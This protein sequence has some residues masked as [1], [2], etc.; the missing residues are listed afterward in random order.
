MAGDLYA[1]SRT[2]SP[3]YSKLAMPQMD[4]K[5]IVTLSLLVDSR[6]RDYAKYPSPGSYAVRLPQKFLNVR[7][8]MLVSIEMPATF[9]VFTAARGNSTL[10]VGVDG[11]YVNVTIPDGN[12]TQTSMA[13]AL[14]TALETAFMGPTFTITF[15][16][17]TL[18]CTLL[19][20]SGVAIAV[21]TTTTNT[22]QTGW[23]L[24]YYLGFVKNTVASGTGSVTG[25]RIANMNP[26]QYVVLDIEELNDVREMGLYGSG[27]SRKAFAKI[28]IP[29]NSFEVV[30]YETKTLLNRNEILPPLQKL[31][32]LHVNFRFH[33]GTPVDFGFQEHSFEIQLECTMVR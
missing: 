32:V 22:T 31:D 25:P 10:R 19:V 28:Q 24:G 27:E 4:A 18:Q 9:Y 5:E 29:V 6:D 8:A 7:A 15:S 26:E 14:K 11:T 3:Y 12:Y 33:D 2:E 30:V 17:T 13:L 16:E 23:G 21:D 1:Y 20:S